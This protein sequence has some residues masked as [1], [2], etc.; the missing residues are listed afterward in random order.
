M[1]NFIY[2][3]HHYLWTVSINRL[4]EILL[5]KMRKYG[6]Q[7]GILTVLYMDRL[8]LVTKEKFKQAYKGELKNEEDWK[9]IEQ[10]I[11]D[12]LETFFTNLQSQKEIKNERVGSFFLPK[13]TE[14]ELKLVEQKNEQHLSTYEVHYDG[15]NPDVDPEEMKKSDSISKYVDGRCVRE[16]IHLTIE[17]RKRK[18]CNIM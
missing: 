5:T 18:K 13:L 17:K 16:T 4:R 15:L 6:I 1:P 12:D 8:K 2:C 10:S 9:D 14:D 7:S 3:G 11:G